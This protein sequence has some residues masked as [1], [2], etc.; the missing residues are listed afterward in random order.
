[1]YILVKGV[2][3]IEWGHEPISPSE[4]NEVPFEVDDGGW[5]EQ[6]DPNMELFWDGRSFWAAPPEITIEDLALAIEELASLIGG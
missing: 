3:I 5:I 1:M 6:Q 2:K 4:P